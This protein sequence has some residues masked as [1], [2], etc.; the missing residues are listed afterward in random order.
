MRDAMTG[1][2]ATDLHK[3]KWKRLLTHALSKKRKR[4]IADSN[5]TEDTPA[6]K[7]VK[8]D[9][10][11]TWEWLTAMDQSVYQMLGHGLEW[12]KCK[13]PDRPF[14]DDFEDDEID[15][16]K[17]LVFCMDE[18]QKQLSRTLQLPMSRTS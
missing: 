9:R 8:I 2:P 6:L 7:Q 16:D 5:D 18:E 12:Y 17:C 4:A 10:S 14:N 3:A 11:A 13:T 1:A 15:E